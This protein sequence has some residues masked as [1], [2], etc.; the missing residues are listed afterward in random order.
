MEKGRPRSLR[1]RL[2]LGPVRAAL[3]V[4]ATVA[5]SLAGL[6]AAVSGAGTAGIAKVKVVGWGFQQPAALAVDGQDVFVANAGNNTVTEL[7]LP[8]LT[9]VR[10][11]HGA[12]YHFT[13]PRAAVVYGQDLW[14]LSVAPS[15]TGSVPEAPSI[16]TEVDARTGQL[17]RVVGGSGY[18]M[19]GAQ[20]MT[21]V[22]PDI[23]VVDTGVNQVTEV[24]A[25]T[26]QVVRLINSVDYVFAEPRA[27]TSIGPDVFVAN[28]E[29]GAGGTVTEFDAVTGALVQVIGGVQYKFGVPEAVAAYGPDLFVISPG[30]INSLYGSITEIDTNA[31]TTITTTTTTMVPTTTTTAPTT[32]TGP[33]TTTSTT[34]PGTTTSTTASSTTT[35]TTTGPGGTG[36]TT[37]TTPGP[38]TT[39]TPPP[40]ATVVR[41]MS[42]ARYNL[43]ETL[44]ATVVGNLLYVAD[45]SGSA[46]SG[47][48]S[49]GAL[50]GA[51]SVLEIDAQNG[52]LVQ[53]TSAASCRINL[54][55]A[56][57]SAG[58]R[59]LVA[60]VGDN[61]ITAL[62]ASS[63]LCI[64]ATA[65]SS[66]QFDHPADM[67]VA[68]GH[69]V[70]G[71]DTLGVL[72]STV[73]SAAAFA[74]Q[75]TEVNPSTGALIRVLRGGGYKFNMPGALAAS[76]KDVFVANVQ[77][78]SVTEIDADTG[79][80]VRVISLGSPAEVAPTTLGVWGHYL[81][82]AA[83]HNNKALSGSISEIDMATG[84]TVTTI[85]GKQYGF[86][87]PI[88]LAV[89]GSDLFV[90]T[91]HQNKSGNDDSVL[92]EVDLATGQ[93]VRL[94]N[95][96]GAHIS[97]AREVLA[98]GLYLFVLNAGPLALAGGT[99]GYGRGSLA[100]I[101]AKTG[102][103]IRVISGAPYDLRG[104]TAMAVQGQDLY[105]ADAGANAVTEIDP[106]T[107]ALVK[108]LQGRQ[109]GFAD[110]DG[111]ATWGDH[112]YIA[113]GQGNSVTDIQL[114]S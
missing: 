62:S 3:A 75:L 103:L 49:G 36:T 100:Q 34:A 82:V 114:A 16:L 113:N 24:D 26:G 104:A 54:P 76:G 78:A 48:G 1:A 73:L 37:T 94:I 65:G 79:G 86:G 111:E 2:H 47:G 61:T 41:V 109:Y 98:D 33:G 31:P 99:I 9:L 6:P 22:G 18:G 25:G 77:S 23:F 95:S 8:T 46:S 21:V 91:V 38:T 81:L 44:A 14:V 55:F 57:A 63:G 112:L 10:V 69:L 70:V 72:L 60:S 4:A 74:P 106:A 92:T 107:G 80:V 83:I 64:G 15:A 58:E 42:G 28:D 7:S 66:Y 84:R 108:L 67:I 105:V 30:L 88:S 19:R 29:G 32:T 5:L 102:V 53:D 59:V 96:A 68:H 51:G 13:Q 40:T 20:A 52:V 39:T 93:L 101:N 17:V 11:I 87:V 71:G 50:L 56:F 35:T 110:P 85:S 43:G 45:L 97:Q 12:Q 27:I 90:A 89:A